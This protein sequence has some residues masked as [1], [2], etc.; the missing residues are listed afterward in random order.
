MLR[1][2]VSPG[3]SGLIAD[4]IAEFAARYSEASLRV[5]F[6]AFSLVVCGR[7]A[8]SPSTDGRN[9]QSI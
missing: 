2:K 9:I 7:H 1:L 8:I 3:I 4:P 5:T 6:G